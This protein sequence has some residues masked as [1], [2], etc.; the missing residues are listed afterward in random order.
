MSTHEQPKL[1]GRRCQCCDCGEYFNGERGFDRHRIGAYGV[2]RCCLSVAEMTA[3]GWYRNAAG[4]WAIARLDSAG[5]ARIWPAQ[6]D[7]APL[8]LADTLAPVLHGAAAGAT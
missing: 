1:T 7:P 5:R 8:P 6:G 3:R 4:F 2:D